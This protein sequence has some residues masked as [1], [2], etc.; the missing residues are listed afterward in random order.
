M[1]YENEREKTAMKPHNNLQILWIHLRLVAMQLN[2]IKWVL[3][4][5]KI[6]EIEL[7]KFRV[8]AV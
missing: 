3:N 2:F 6:T 1:D 5:T 4:K 8:V 7:I